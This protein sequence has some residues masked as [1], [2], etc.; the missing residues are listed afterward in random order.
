MARSRTQRL[1]PASAGAGR[2]RKRTW[3]LSIS[4]ALP[5]LAAGP[6]LAAKWDIQPTLSSDVTYTDNVSLSRAGTERSDWVTQVTPGISIAGT[7]AQLKFNAN[8]GAQFLH[9]AE[10]GGNGVNHQFNGSGNAEL[11]KQLLFIDARGSV[12]QQNVSLLGPQTDSNV[13]NTGN[14]ATVRS[15]FVSPY[16]RHDFGA[17]AQAEARLTHSTLSTDAADGLRSQTNGINLSIASGPAFKLY[18]W[19]VAYNR[20]SIDYS[21]QIPDVTTE[22]ISAGGKRMITSQ[23][24]LTSSVGYEKSDY[25]ALGKS[26]SGAFW[27]AGLEW[28]PTP[29]TRVT[30]TTGHRYYGNTRSFDLSH[31]TRLTTWGASYS[32]SVTNTHAQAL[33]PSSFSTAGYLDT[34]FLSSVPDPA[35]RQQ[36][37]QNFIT[38]NGLPSNL[39]VPLNF[40]TTQTILVKRWQG[41]FGIHGVRNT[42]LANVFRQSSDA[43]TA[44]LAAT[45]TGDFATSSTVQQTGGS[46]IWNW[47]FATHVSSNLSAG[48]TRSEF[49]DIGRTDDAK[50]FR[51]GV[52]QQFQPRLSGSVNF[53][54]IRN[55]SSIAGAG[56]VENAVTA[57][58]GYRF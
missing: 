53:R 10:S 42:L 34:L 56:Y 16:L 51:L 3:L 2:C 55:D 4:A 11:V 12:F 57:A 13:N 36:A 54:N 39:S 28:T 15:F 35:A 48:V 52:S 45:G 5:A 44:G 24:G 1:R 17:S 25:A 14:R 50:Y 26:P 21:A 27:N 40:L 37:V 9:R 18:T 46:V 20:S 29:R 7:G 22:T 32:E 8:Y 23:F 47:R 49:P 30:A 33:L 58:L 43:L 38:Q 41:S 6:V 31:R 19:N